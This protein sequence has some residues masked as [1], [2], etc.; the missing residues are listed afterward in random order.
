MNFDTDTLANCENCEHAALITTT[1][2]VVLNGSSVPSE[3]T[4]YR[5][6][7]D[8]TIRSTDD[9]GQ[10]LCSEYKPKEVEA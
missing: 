6:E 10:M 5:C 3:S 2:N 1:V 7:Y 8:G 9:I 4:H